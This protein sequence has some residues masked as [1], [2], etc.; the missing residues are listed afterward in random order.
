V[1]ILVVE[2]FQPL[3]R[4]LVL[5][6][7]K[8]GYAV[9]AASDGEEGWYFAKDQPYDA[10]IVD[11]DLPKLS[12]TDLI[13]RIRA[14]GGKVPILILSAKDAI[15]DRVT[16]LDVGADDYLV[17]PFAAPELLARLRSLV[18]RANDRVDNII[19]IADLHIDTCTH[20]VRRGERAIFLTYR[21]YQALVLLARRP[22]DVLQREDLQAGL[23]A[24]EDDVSENFIPSLIARLRGKLH[25]P[26]EPQLLHTVRGH[27]YRLAT[28]P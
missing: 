28:D 4:S 18:R 17:K 7:G 22:G 10:L 16:G 9:D 5:G 15:D 12:G 2:D 13:K 24:F 27:G 25:G 23:L 21:E 6:L 20:T 14:Q 11:L 19:H 26:H 3:Q 8:A 1:R